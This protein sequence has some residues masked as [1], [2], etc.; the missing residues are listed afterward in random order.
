[1][2]T[3]TQIYSGAP[4]DVSSS[5]RT[6]GPRVI[7]IG[8]LHGR[9]TWKQIVRRHA[10]EDERPSRIV[11]LGDYVDSPTVSPAVQ[12]YNLQEVIALAG[13]EKNRTDGVTLLIGNHDYQY[14]P[15]VNEKYTGYQPA[16]RASFERL[17]SDNFD[18]FS[19]ATSA[20][21]WLITHAGLTTEFMKRIGMMPNQRV[22]I[23]SDLNT[24]FKNNWINDWGFYQRDLTGC[25]DHPK[26]SPLWVRPE[27]L[28][29]WSPAGIGQVV[30]HTET[31]EI[32]KFGQRILTVDTLQG[33]W[34]LEI[35]DNVSYIKRKSYKKGSWKGIK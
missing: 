31:T 18:L 17:F 7:V 9:N 20:H 1:M 6:S 32:K 2:A 22:N 33:G 14:L 27:V 13:H 16:M 34:H 15:G 5:P 4:I 29:K 23:V 30:G 3:V 8:D 24:H 10:S 11:F 12:L 26:Q 35:L 28:L 25:G 21:N 19:V